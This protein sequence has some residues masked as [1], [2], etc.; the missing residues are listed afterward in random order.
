MPSRLK[1][2]RRIQH[3][4]AALALV[5]TLSPVAALSM[6]SQ[7]GATAPA[8]HHDH[9]HIH[10]APDP[11]SSNI[12]AEYGERF[13]A[14]DYSGDL[15]PTSGEMP[16]FGMGLFALIPYAFLLAAIFKFAGAP[17]SKAQTAFGILLPVPNPPPR[18]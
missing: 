9:R 10:Y 6:A 8:G 17:I 5:A 3:L 1:I 18:T 15:D 2:R 12:A 11:S 13:D 16:G 14:A 4:L 7:A